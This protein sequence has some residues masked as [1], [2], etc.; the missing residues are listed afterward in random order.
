MSIF[1]FRRLLPLALVV[2]GSFAITSCV[3]HER[4]PG[5]GREHHDR[6][7]R[8]DDHRDYDRH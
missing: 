5:Y 1:S 2:A 7:D 6:H 3:V 8:R 4:R